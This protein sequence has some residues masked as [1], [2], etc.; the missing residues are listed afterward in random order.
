MKFLSLLFLIWFTGWAGCSMPMMKTSWSKPGAQP[1]EFER[2]SSYCEQ[3]QG[4]TG[5]GH[6]AGYDVCMQ[7]K[8]WFLIEERVN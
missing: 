5:L 1:G 7:K 3:D 8:G 6:G 2:D 4:V